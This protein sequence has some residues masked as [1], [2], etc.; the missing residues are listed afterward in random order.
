M[1]NM[2]IIKEI[3]SITEKFAQ[4]IEKIIKDIDT[5]SNKLKY[6]TKKFFKSITEGKMEFKDD[7]NFESFFSEKV[8]KKGANISNE[9][10]DGINICT[11]NGLSKIWECR[12]LFVF[13]K[14]IFF[15]VTYLT[16]LLEIINEDLNDKI[17][18][19]VYLLKENFKKYIDSIINFIDLRTKIISTKYTKFQKNEWYN[20]CKMYEVSKHKIQGNLKKIKQIKYS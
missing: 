20:L 19:I 18:Y 4:K 8:S 16:N 13:I 11:E 5:E 17:G 7:K 6:E 10:I 1:K 2:L 15:R 14:S 9:I 3:K 12:T